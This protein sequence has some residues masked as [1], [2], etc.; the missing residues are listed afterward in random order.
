MIQTD[1][2]GY[3]KWRGTCRIMCELICD[4][5]KCSFYKTNEQYQMDRR[6]YSPK[7]E[8]TAET[9]LKPVRCIETGQEFGSV[10]EAA[11]CCNVS[12]SNITQCLRGH[13]PTAGGYHWEYI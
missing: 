11:Y 5:R 1:C 7:L 2:F 4:G 3:N 8:Q 13:A 12:P 6:K 9:N 10:K